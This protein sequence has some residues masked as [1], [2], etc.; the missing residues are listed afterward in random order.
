MPAGRATF[1][2][3]HFCRQQRTITAKLDH[4]G[5]WATLQRIPGRNYYIIQKGKNVQQYFKEDNTPKIIKN[6]DGRA[7]LPGSKPLSLI[8]QDKFF[9]EFLS[10]IFIYSP[11]ERLKPLDAL[12]HPWIVDGLPA[13]IRE[14]HLSYIKL[15]LKK[16]FESVD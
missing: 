16:N 12:L 2:R 10:K 5:G 15:K 4:A 9:A 1:G 13:S 3:A 7:I 11:H 8:I 14:Q 6:K